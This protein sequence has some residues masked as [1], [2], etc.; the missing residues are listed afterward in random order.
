MCCVLAD[1]RAAARADDR[2]GIASV[3]TAVPDGSLGQSHDG[4]RLV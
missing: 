2:D 3:H 4:R 1:T